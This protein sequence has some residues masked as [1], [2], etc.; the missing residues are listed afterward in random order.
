MQ[1]HSL[2]DYMRRFFGAIQRQLVYAE[3]TER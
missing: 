3:I 2:V 1:V